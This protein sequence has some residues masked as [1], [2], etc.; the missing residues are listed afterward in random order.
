MARTENIQ[1]ELISGATAFDRGD[2]FE[3]P[4]QVRA[5]FTLANMTELFGDD[6][7]EGGCEWATPAPLWTQGQPWTQAD[8]SEWATLVIGGRWHCRF[9]PMTTQEAATLLGIAEQTVRQAIA[10]NRLSAVKRGRDW[11]IDPVD[12]DRYDRERRPAPRRS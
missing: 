6:W 7:P 9:E 10:D 4:T 11:W 2:L 5:Y 3:S 12:V 8:L 1:R